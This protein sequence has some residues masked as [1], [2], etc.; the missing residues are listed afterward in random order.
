[1]IC[2]K[3]NVKYDSVEGY[4][5][6]R[7]KSVLEKEDCCDPTLKQNFKTFEKK[8][9]SCQKGCR[10]CKCKKSGTKGSVFCH[11]MHSCT[12]NK[13]PSETIVI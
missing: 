2:Y 6:F 9:C 4:E 3:R 7:K 5:G 11:P 8:G 1:M 10:S 13:Y 12:N